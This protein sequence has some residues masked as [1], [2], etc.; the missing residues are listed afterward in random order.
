[1]Q[2]VKVSAVVT[3]F[4]NEQTIAKCIES[5]SFADEIVVLDSYSTDATLKVLKKMNCRV[6]QQRFQGFSRQKQAAIDLA[7]NDWVI[8]LDSDEYLTRQARQQLSLWTKS[9]PQCDAYSLPRREWVF[10]QWSHQW[11]KMNDFVRLFY[12]PKAHVSNAL[13]HESIVTKGT[14]ERMPAIIKHKGE[15]SVT[16]KLEKINKYSLLAAQDKFNKGKTVGVLKLALYPFWYFFKQY[17]LRRQIFNGV[18]GLINSA[19]NTQYAFLKY[20][21]LYELQQGKKDL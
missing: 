1:M 4:N 9:Q 11:V 6:H 8:L 17:F 18:A 16:L 3:C 20:V 15:T 19:M 14:I 13:V 12:R 10:W 2:R 7:E 21:K 5:L